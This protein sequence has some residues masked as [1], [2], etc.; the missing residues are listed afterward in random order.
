MATHSVPATQEAVPLDSLETVPVQKTFSPEYLTERERVLNEVMAEG[1]RRIH[2][3]FAR[4]VALG[5]IDQNGKRIKTELP[6]DMLPGSDRDFG[7]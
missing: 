5:I 2:R 1:E 6:A 7:G 4:G 3:S